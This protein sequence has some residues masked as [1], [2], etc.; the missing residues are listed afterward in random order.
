MC[1]FKASLVYIKSEDKSYIERTCLQKKEKI[2]KFLAGAMVL[3]VGRLL[4]AS[5]TTRGQSQ[6]PHSRVER[7]LSCP[8]TFSSVAHVHQPHPD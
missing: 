2:T 5:L 4:P 1:E 8:F 6:N 3:Q 7:E